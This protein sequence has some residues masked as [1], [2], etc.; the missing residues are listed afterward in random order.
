MEVELT[1]NFLD[2]QTFE[3]IAALVEEINETW[4]RTFD[5]FK[6]P[7]DHDDEAEAWDKHSLSR[8]HIIMRKLQR[9]TSERSQL[10]QSL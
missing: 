1:T 3:S 7:T 2:G 8:H 6:N 4:E 10:L 5:A 9:V